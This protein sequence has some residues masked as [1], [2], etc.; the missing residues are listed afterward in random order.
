MH[1]LCGA[2]KW[3]TLEWGMPV[4]HQGNVAECISELQQSISLRCDTVGQDWE[5]FTKCDCKAVNY[6][7]MKWAYTKDTY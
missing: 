4:M 6:K 5:I 2:I 7:L 3:R 1:Y